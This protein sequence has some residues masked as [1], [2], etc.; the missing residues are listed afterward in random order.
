M[1]VFEKPAE[2]EHEVREHPN[3]QDEVILKILALSFGV[4]CEEW[5]EVVDALNKKME[6]SITNGHLDYA[7]LTELICQDYDDSQKLE[8]L[9]HQILGAYLAYTLIMGRPLDIKLKK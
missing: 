9:G 8:P 6:K 1:A 2:K 7:K 5:Q 3:T 4:S